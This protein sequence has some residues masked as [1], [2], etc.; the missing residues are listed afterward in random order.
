MQVD[1]KNVVEDGRAD[2]LAVGDDHE[3]LAGRLHDA[4]H[5]DGVVHVVG[6]EGFDAPRFGEVPYWDGGLP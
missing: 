5:D 2:L 6:L 1:R 4:L 3:R